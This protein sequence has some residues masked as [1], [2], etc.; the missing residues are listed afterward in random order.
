MWKKLEARTEEESRK[1][2]G[3]M[4]VAIYDLTDGRTLL[5]NGDEVFPQASL[6][7]VAVLAELMHQQEQSEKGTAGKARL[8]DVY[9][10]DKKDLVADSDIMEG[11]TP[12][13]T[14]VTNRDLAAM[15]S[16]VSDNAATNVLIERLGM[17]NVNALMDSQGLRHTRLQRK[18]MD[19]KA[20]SEG[21]ENLSTP[22]EMMALLA[23]IYQGRVVGKE[24][25]GEYFNILS[26]HSHYK[27]YIRR[28]VPDGVRVADK[29]GE[30][31]GVRT[32]AGVVFAGQR[33]YVICVMATYL[34]D[35]SEGE[36]AISR[37]STAA[38]DYFD[39][40]GRASAYGRV[41]SPRNSR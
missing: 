27:T 11:L 26:L 36:R 2:D 15:L 31:E 13:V 34:K 6:I 24:L 1:L 12:G 8:D 29:E 40:V 21:R 28:G 14:R 22:R 35:E 10:M 9:V 5:V 33:P 20:A 16:A 38:F 25:A 17:A 4:G 41:I 39:R 30:L 7:K 3:V 18:M 37:I 32:T 19:L 23:A